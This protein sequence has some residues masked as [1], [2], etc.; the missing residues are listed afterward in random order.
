MNTIVN[1]LTSKNP[2]LVFTKLTLILGIVLAF[3]LLY[4]ISEPP[5]RKIENFMQKEAFV[6]KTNQ[7]VYDEFYVDVY[8]ELYETKNRVQKELTQ[9]LKMTE[10]T[11][12][13]SSFLDIGSGT[14]F[15]VDQLTQAGYV[16]YGIDKSSEMV[17]YSENKYPESEYK[18]ADVITDPMLFDNSTFT[19]ILCTNFTFY[20][21]DDKMTFFKN[22]YF[23]LKPNGYLILHLANRHKFSIYKPV[24][25]KPFFEL[26]TKKYPPRITDTMVDYEDYK[27]TSLY[28]FPKNKYDKST[29]LVVFKEKFIDKITK[30]VRENEQTLYM[31]SISTI[32]KMANQAGFIVKGKID[33]VKINKKGPYADRFQFLYVLERVM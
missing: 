1:I 20:L 16:A 22:C 14:G 33:M 10:P 3:I 19:H 32:L 9:V 4:K 27:Y 5:F 12:K 29:E 30:N 13:H 31:D 17:K 24:A 7:D 11:V 18:C 25:K 26:P 15:M 21:F 28:Q 6:M 2:N 8:D 23:W